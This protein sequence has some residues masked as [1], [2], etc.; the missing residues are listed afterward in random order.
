[1]I[2]RS[3]LVSDEKFWVGGKKQ[4]LNASETYPHATH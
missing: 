4:I 3:E 2:T 1:M